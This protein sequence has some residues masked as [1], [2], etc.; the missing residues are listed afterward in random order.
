MAVDR[1]GSRDVVEG[2]AEGGGAVAVAVLVVVCACVQV[3]KEACQLLR[4]RSCAVSEGE[5]DGKR[6]LPLRHTAVVVS[7]PSFF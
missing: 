2:W 6:A 3:R 5:V 4:Q 7:T 1:T